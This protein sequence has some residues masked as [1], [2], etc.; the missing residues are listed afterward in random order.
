VATSERRELV[1]PIVTRHG[2][3]AVM[4]KPIDNDRLVALIRQTLGN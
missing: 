3:L 1:E 2:T 4:E